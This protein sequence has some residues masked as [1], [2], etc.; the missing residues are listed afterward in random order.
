MKLNSKLSELIIVQ[1]YSATLSVPANSVATHDF[2]WSVPD[3]YALAAVTLMCGSNVIMSEISSINVGRVKVR[4]FGENNV[5][6]ITVTAK[7][8][9]NKNFSS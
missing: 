3:G 2:N 8:I 9:F 4:N 1:N 5:T 6:N 7:V